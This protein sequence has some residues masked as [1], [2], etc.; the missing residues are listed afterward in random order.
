M[1]AIPMPEG[2][3]V[4]YPYLKVRLSAWCARPCAAMR[5]VRSPFRHNLF[6]RQ[7]LNVALARFL[8]R[9]LGN[10]S[11]GK[12]P[13]DTI[14]SFSLR[15]GLRL[16]ASDP[17]PDRHRRVTAARCA[18]RHTPAACGQYEGRS[19]LTHP[20]GGRT[21]NASCFAMVD[22][23]EPHY[24]DV[25]HEDDGCWAHYFGALRLCFQVTHERVKKQCCLIEYVWPELE[26]E[27]G[28]PLTAKYVSF[29]QKRYEVVDVESVLYR[30]PLFTPPPLREP[31][32]G[33][34]PYRV[35]NY[36]IYVN[37]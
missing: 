11:P 28:K 19:A 10:R 3:P 18:H 21:V 4:L 13:A 24:V 5:T 32:P 31:G 35:L 1:Q 23:A 30:A 33:E 36:D 12:L 27:D 9:V 37:W 16:R 22:E 17:D 25:N 20:G 2:A 34:R 7:V 6:A 29:A 14:A 8:F 15:P 26:T